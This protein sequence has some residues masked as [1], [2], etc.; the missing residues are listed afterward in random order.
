M[1]TTDE[2][3]QTLPAAGSPAEAGPD[4]RPANGVRTFRRSGLLPESALRKLRAQQEEFARALGARLSMY[5]RLDVNVVLAGLQTES[6]SKF[7]AGMATPVHLTLLKLDPVRGIGL[8]EIPPRLGLSIVDRQLGGTGKVENAD[9]LL[10]EIET[11]LLDQT[12]EIVLGEWCAQWRE[13]QELKPALLGHEIDVHFLN[14]IPRETMML[15]LTFE[16]T[17]G[18]CKERFR[19]GLPFHSLEALIR[20]LAE[21]FETPGAAPALAAATAPR[22]NAQFDDLPVALDAGC[23]G[24]RLTARELAALKIGDTLPVDAQQL[25]AVQLRVGGKTKFAGTLG[26]S[27]GRWAVQL[28]RKLEA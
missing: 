27:E 28:T 2:I 24:V 8:L 18:E 19:L 4:A 17:L 9:R 21:S 14:A 22:W 7:V 25:S 26:T 23:G 1:P 12:S 10:T 6:F 3:T 11:A 20:R 15:E 5:L 13:L 16:T